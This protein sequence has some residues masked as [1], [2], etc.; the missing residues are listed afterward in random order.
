MNNKGISFVETLLTVAIILVLTGFLIP[1][2]SK[3]YESLFIKKLDLHVSEVAY[4]AAKQIKD[5][6]I[7]AGSVK[8]D[9][10]NFQ[11]SFDGQ[12]LCVNYQLFKEVEMKCFT[13]NGLI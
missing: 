3:L 10:N 5:K 12:K 4:N 2:S 8:I 7:N 6:G 11:W 1:L 13:Q 9:D